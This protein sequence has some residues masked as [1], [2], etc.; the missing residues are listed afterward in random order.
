MKRALTV[1]VAAAASV[2]MIDLAVGHH[3]FIMFDSENPIELSGK[4]HS[5]KFTSPHT[6]IYLT[7]TGKDGKAE[8]W[9]LEGAN[10]GTLI[11]AGWSRETIKPGDELI[12]T[13]LP[14]RSG[15]PAG[16]WDEKKI[17]RQNGE[18]IVA[19]K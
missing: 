2:A 7:V 13:V 15:A 14:L 6:I 19:V 8:D 3:S 17:R 12:M 1:I 18:P 5:F 11:R 10:A 9:N 16:A 4:L